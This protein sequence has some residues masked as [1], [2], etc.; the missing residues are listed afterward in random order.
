[1]TPASA[2][3]LRT[4]CVAAFSLDSALIRSSAATRSPVFVW[5]MS[6]AL[7]C[8]RES[9]VCC[10][11][12]SSG[13]AGN[14]GGCEEG[15][16]GSGDCKRGA[17]TSDSCK[18]LK[19][20]ACKSSGR[21]CGTHGFGTF[22]SSSDSPAFSNSC[23]FNSCSNFAA[24][25]KSPDADERW[26]VSLSNCRMFSTDS[27]SGVL[28]QLEVT[29]LSTARS[30]SPVEQESSSMSLTTSLALSTDSSLG[31]FAASEALA[32]SNAR[33]KSPLVEDL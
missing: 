1:M 22:A 26:S 20:P 23:T 3:S 29:T 33:F 13:D 31:N 27:P 18:L 8:F 15:A 11:S 6:C 28:G 19:A 14:G 5:R 2:L 17:L 12:A 25:S 9:S 21:D 30:R 24:R 4:L 7:K 16:G 32:I 10:A